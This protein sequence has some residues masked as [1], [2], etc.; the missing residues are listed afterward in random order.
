MQS[1]TFDQMARSSI[2][3]HDR[4]TSL[5]AIGAALGASLFNP[6]TA[7]ARKR[8]KRKKRCRREKKQC[9]R[10]AQNFCQ[11]RLDPEECEAFLLPCCRSCKTKSTLICVLD[12][13]G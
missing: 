2:P 12:L 7:E 11:D 4:R 6:G 1:S 9:R 8:N 13:T 5:M 3:I 10:A